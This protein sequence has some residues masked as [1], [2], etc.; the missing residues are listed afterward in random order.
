M[1]RVSRSSLHTSPNSGSIPPE[2]PRPFKSHN[3]Q[4][5]LTIFVIPPSVDIS[6]WTFK[7]F[8]SFSG[9]I[10]YSPSPTEFPLCIMCRQEIP[11]WGVVCFSIE[12]RQKLINPFDFLGPL[13]I[14]GKFINFNGSQKKLRLLP[15]LLRGNLH[16]H[17]KSSVREVKK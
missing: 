10:K 2:G 12:L 3:N 15:T 17:T 11:G 6:Q 8:P 7:G 1:V 14:I 4:Q 9:S 5:N 13:L 16:T